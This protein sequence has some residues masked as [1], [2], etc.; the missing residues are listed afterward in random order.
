MPTVK[1][2]ELPEISHLSTNTEATLVV[3]V[4]LE[5]GTTGK[6][7]LTVLGEGLYAYQP[8]KVGENQVLFSNT[9]AQFSGN[10]ITYLQINNQNFDAN[11]SS[12]YV[13]SASDTD[14]TNKYID[15]GI[16]GFDFSDP[17]YSSM[18]PY[19][20]YVY[21]R[22][23]TDT[24]TT[25]NLVIGTA[26]SF[27]NIVYIVGGTT[28]SNI[29]ARMTKTDLQ[30]SAGYNIKFGDGSI[31]SVAASPVNYSQAAFALANNNSVLSQASFNVANTA[32][33]NTFVIQGVDASQNVR[34]DFSNTRMA[35]IEDTDAS[36][37]VRLDF[38][39]TRMDISDGVDI[40]QNSRIGIVESVNF[41]QNA[42]ITIIENTDVSQ[43]VRLDFSNTAINATNGKMQS[44]YDKANNALANTSGTFDG[45]L[46]ITGNTNAQAVN[47]ANLFVAG[48]TEL[49]G[50][51]TINA[52]TFMTGA[53]TVN[54]TMVLANT[55]FSASEAAFRITAAGSSQTPTQAG[56]LM[57][58]TS[59]ANTPARVLIDSFG[60]SNTAYP[61]IAGRNA[62]G[63]V[64][65]PTATQNNDILLRIAGN[66]YGTTGFAPFGDARIDFV[67]TEN[68]TDTARGSRIKFWNT[69]NGSN[70][71]NEIASFNADSVYFTGVLAPQK[72][73]IYSPTMLVGNQTAFTIDFSTTSLIKAEL[74]ADLTI[75]LSNYNYGKVVE[76]WLTN[77]GGTQRTVTHGCSALNST[78]NSTTFNM[79]A[80]SSAYLR[81]F[82]INGDLANTFVSV[83]YA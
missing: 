44:A 53:V 15:M 74:V 34:L 14:N 31:Q 81:Y 38:S 6:V 80:T 75:S 55:T 50:N 67:A 45:S 66:S 33:A 39:N 9:I 13:A 8:L 2:S 63:T 49:V 25:G 46:T 64:N 10:S 27:A 54:S 70:V 29:V 71:V 82:S 18:D 41:S 12:D 48:T 1:I 59:K 61:I 11:G 4:D 30:L 79:A 16:N 36:Q 65:T 51:L 23:P 78:T 58:L 73:F 76:V 32:S 37:N 26:S 7:D 62:R 57:Q 24:S 19:D 3:G 60:T 20:G 52:N 22:G 5:T 21:V 83:Q 43:N 69:P 68:H 77:T 56:T 47:T 35:I 17:D 42:R 72:G 28:T 40:T